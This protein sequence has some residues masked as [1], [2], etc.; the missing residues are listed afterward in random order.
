[1]AGTAA[2][3]AT[4][5][6]LPN[7]LATHAAEA[8]SKKS[9]SKKKM[10]QSET[11]VTQL[12]KSM[13]EEQKKPICFEFDHQLRQR[14][15]NNWHITKSRVG[16]VFNKDQQDLVR[17]IFVG[18]H[19]PEYAANVLKAVEHDNGRGG[20]GGCAVAF[21]GEPGT[22]KFEFVFTGRHVTRRCDG[23]SVEG[24]AFGG[25]IFYGHAAK[26]FNEP[27]D[28]AGNVYWF[29][30]IA[31]NKAFQML[32]RKQR[33]QSLRTDNRRERGNQT[34]AITRNKANR[35]GVPIADLSADQK[36]EVSKTMAAL[37]APFRK[38]DADEV[39]KIVNST[40]GLDSLHM[41]FYKNRDI[42]N[43]GVWDV[44]QIEGPQMVWYFRGAPHVHTW[45]H[46][47]NPKSTA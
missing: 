19:S 1:M 3:I 2:G 6:V 31:A 35:H 47:K 5:V 15:D 18:L 21:F 22:G 12:Y 38:E 11:L 45:V 4:S 17:Q 40:G 13:T 32:D 24:A 34:V 9:K 23:D 36:A 28:H 30:G 14:V 44:F 43:D 20:I 46:V 25:P 26:S 42:G 7:P 27:A 29:Q 37:L 33:E 41:A 39:M 10:P 16:T 8:P